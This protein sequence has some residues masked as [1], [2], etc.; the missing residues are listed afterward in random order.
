MQ[1]TRIMQ[2]HIKE[3]DRYPET[4]KHANIRKAL[5]F[6]NELLKIS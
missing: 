6:N 1:V 5:L 4:S 3:S 2:K